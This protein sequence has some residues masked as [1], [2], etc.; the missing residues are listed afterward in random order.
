[1]ASDDR[2]TQAVEHAQKVLPKLIAGLIAARIRYGMDEG[3]KRAFADAVLSMPLPSQAVDREQLATIAHGDLIPL[4]PFEN[5][6]SPWQ[7]VEDALD[8]LISAGWVRGPVEQPPAM[9]PVGGQKLALAIYQD[10]LANG[11]HQNTIAR[12]LLARYDIRERGET[13]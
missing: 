10:G 7:A 9:P 3:L 6:P 1:M 5:I 11:C 2:I 12:K 4:N 8:R 13:A